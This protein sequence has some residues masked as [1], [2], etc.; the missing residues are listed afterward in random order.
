LLATPLADLDDEDR[1]EVQITA[2]EASVHL[3]TTA[4]CYT[5]HLR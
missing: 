5:V 3:H 2:S 1:C 4:A